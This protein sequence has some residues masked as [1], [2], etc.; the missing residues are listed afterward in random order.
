MCPTRSDQWIQPQVV[1]ES[2]FGEVLTTGETNMKKLV[3]CLG[4]GV[5]A[6]AIGCGDGGGGGSAAPTAPAATDA[7]NK[8][9]MDKMT[10]G[11]TDGA[12]VADGDKPAADGD[13]PAADGDKP[14]ADG[15]KPAA[16][17]KPKED[18]PAADDKPKEDKPAADD[19]PKED[20]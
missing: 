8:A 4:C 10:K 5:V 6:F 19:K 18:K 17:D 11:S 12:A 7:S 20:K 15:D 13:K 1:C 3:M 2:A 16:D 9:Y 14:A